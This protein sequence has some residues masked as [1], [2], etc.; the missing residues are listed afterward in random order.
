MIFE[1]VDGADQKLEAKRDHVIGVYTPIKEGDFDKNGITYYTPKA[2]AKGSTKDYNSVY[3][4]KTPKSTGWLWEKKTYDDFKVQPSTGIK[5]GWGT[6]DFT[7]PQTIASDPGMNLV[8]GNTYSV[9]L[10]WG[11]MQDWQNFPAGCR[12]QKDGNYG[13]T[14]NMR[15]DAVSQGS[16]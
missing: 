9:T 7:R 13:K 6:I 3:F 8:V 15:I 12:V 5:D 2:W 14:K 1:W 4:C 10:S 11:V 16:Y